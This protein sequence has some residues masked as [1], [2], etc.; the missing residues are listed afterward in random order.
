MK[1]T[2]FSEQTYDQVTLTERKGARERLG[3]MSYILITITRRP[4]MSEGMAN[5]ILLNTHAFT[6]RYT[7]LSS[8]ALRCQPSGRTIFAKLV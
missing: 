2:M 8:S 3:A 4:I 7:D 6:H 5:K 1:L